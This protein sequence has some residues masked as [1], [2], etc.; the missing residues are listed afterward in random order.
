MFN[1]GFMSFDLNLEYK[2]LPFDNLTPYLFGGIGTNA[3]DYFN[4]LDPKLQAG[5]GIEYL[6][7]DNIGIYVFGEHNLVFSDKLDNVVSGSIDDM[8]YRFGLGVN[9]YL[10]KPNT[11]F[12]QRKELER[13][14]KAEFR[15]LKKENRRQMQEKNKLA[16]PI[17]KDN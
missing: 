12:N 4:T 16:R 1:E 17:K 8:F 10:S 9:I 3:L 2:I 7:K 11:K 13:L 6:V 14:K 5:L 15:A